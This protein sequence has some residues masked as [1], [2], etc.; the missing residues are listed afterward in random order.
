MSCPAK[1]AKVSTNQSAKPSVKLKLNSEAFVFVL[2]TI[3][4]NWYT[5]CRYMVS[6]SREFYSMEQFYRQAGKQT[7]ITRWMMMIDTIRLISEPNLN[8]ER[9]TERSTI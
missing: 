8:D 1:K 7:M 5:L 4:C 2:Q 6:R 9:N 3:I